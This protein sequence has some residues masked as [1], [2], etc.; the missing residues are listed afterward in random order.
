MRILITGAAGKV[1]RAL[2][3]ELAQTGHSLRLAD[4]RP[5]EKPE[6]ESLRLDITDGAAV[7][8]AAQ[9][10]DAIAHL[11]YGADLNDNSEKDIRL[12]Y[13]VNAKG[14]HFLLW[15]GEQVGIKRF[16]YT[17]TLSVFGA[18]EAFARGNLH[19]ESPPQ[20]V[21]PYGLTKYFGEEVCRYYAETRGLSVVC[22]RLCCV[23]VED[24]W[25]KCLSWKLKPDTTAC[26]RAHRG[27]ATHVNDVAHAV[28]LA[29]T[30]PNLRYEV[31]H[32]AADNVGRV[33]SIDRA[34]E[35]LG[36][37]P[38]YSLDPVEAVSK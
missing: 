16:V 14:T 36:F 35:V 1:G 32:I 8:R 28:H 18:S 31:L 6:G 15:A 34:R 29:L 25:P 3:K 20:P 30:V 9:G 2:R 26:A 4:I 5:I 7:L 21:N 11:A 19:E 17:S 10:M 24:E 37:W 27:M 13:D 22:L 23:T 33:T 12:N 38:R